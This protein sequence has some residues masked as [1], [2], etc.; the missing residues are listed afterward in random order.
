[1]LLLAT[2][3]VFIASILRY[4]VDIVPL[5]AVLASLCAWWG[6]Q[7]L[8]KSRFWRTILL[9]LIVLLAVAG[10][11]AGLFIGF[12]VYPNRFENINPSLYRAIAAFFNG[13]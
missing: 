10:I 1:L 5:M 3:S 8:E 11:A 9:I 2:L 4:L 13:K 6:L 7:F 12:T